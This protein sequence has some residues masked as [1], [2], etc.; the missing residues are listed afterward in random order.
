AKW[1]FDNT[2]DIVANHALS[3][4]DPNVLIAIA[5]QPLPVEVIVRG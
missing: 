4:P 2:R 5:A 3:M 1:W